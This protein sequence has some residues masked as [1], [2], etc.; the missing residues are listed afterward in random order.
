MRRHP[1]FRQGEKLEARDGV[2]AET[3]YRKAIE[4]DPKFAHAYLDLCAMLGESHHAQAAVS[5]YDGAIVACPDLALVRFNRALA[6]EDVGRLDEAMASYERSLTLDPSLADAHFNIARL[7]E[8][9][10]DS[11]SALRHLKAY[12]RLQPCWQLALPCELPKCFHFAG[13]SCPLAK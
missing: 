8:R 11:Q 9:R 6:L 4:R 2:A 12:R 13:W 3:A 7:K 10:G 5:L 1:V